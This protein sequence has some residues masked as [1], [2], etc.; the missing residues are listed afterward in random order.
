MKRSDVLTFCSIVLL[1]FA[2]SVNVMG[3]VYEHVGKEDTLTEFPILEIEEPGEILI[4]MGSKVPIMLNY[5]IACPNLENVYTLSVR[6]SNIFVFELK[7]NTTFDIT[8]EDA[9]DIDLILSMQNVSQTEKPFSYTTNSTA[10]ALVTQGSIIVDINGI[11][12][13]IESM[14]IQLK[15]GGHATLSDVTGN[16][17][18]SVIAERRFTVGV[19]RPMTL[20]DIVFRIVIGVAVSLV[21]LGFGCGLNLE[22]VKECLKKPI[23]PG[24]GL[25]CQYI[26]MPLVMF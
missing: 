21:L 7:G 22:V 15:N 4:E 2:C 8:C 18:D 19:L 25:G 16:V 24:I 17:S 12:L 1:I 23:A 26:L 10:P 11:L 14:H 6:S 13:G 9:T 5:T 20:V 3:A